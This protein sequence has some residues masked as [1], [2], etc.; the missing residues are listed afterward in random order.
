MKF[1]C[2]VINGMKYSVLVEAESIDQAEEIAANEYERG[3]EIELDTIVLG[4][5]R[6]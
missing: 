3:E 4:M 5:E 1:L 2:E 6:I